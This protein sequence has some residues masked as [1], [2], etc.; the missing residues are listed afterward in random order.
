MRVALEAV[1]EQPRSFALRGEAGWWEGARVALREPDSRLLGAL[2][3][4][5]EGY[6][7]GRRLLFR[8]RLAASIELVCAFCLEPFAQQFEEP[9]QLLL[10]PAEGTGEVSGP[11][12]VLDPDD[13]EVGRYAGDELD[14]APAVF[15]ALALAWPLQPRC[16]VGCG[17]LCPT[18]GRNR[19]LEPCDCP[20]RTR[21]S[22]FADLAARLER[23]R[24][25]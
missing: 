20:D 4:D 16:R 1:G 21:S 19:N 13:P 25:S 12:I 23:A 10:E 17:G 22:P 5:L 3:L 11:S 2:R 7:L 14:F 9:F 6:R 15:E 8:G 24:S 18:C